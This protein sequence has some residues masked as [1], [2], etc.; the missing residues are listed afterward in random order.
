M[1]RR[2]DAAELLEITCKPLLAV[3]RVPDAMKAGSPAPVVGRR[4]SASKS[5]PAGTDG[6][7]ATFAVISAIVDSFAEPCASHIR[8]RVR[9][10]VGPAVRIRFAPAG[11][12][13]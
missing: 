11:S 5:N 2:K 3:V 12:L 8:R 9:S 1:V 13:L 6:E 4:D 10:E 7:V